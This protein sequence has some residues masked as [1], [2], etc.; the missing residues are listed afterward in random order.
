MGAHEDRLSL[1]EAA[2]PRSNH[3]P[4]RFRIG[5]GGRFIEKTSGGSWIRAGRW[6]AA[7]SCPGKSRQV[8][9]LVIEVEEGIFSTVGGRHQVP[10]LP[11][12][13]VLSRGE[14]FMRKEF[15]CLP[16]S[17]SDATVDGD[18]LPHDRVP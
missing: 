9:R 11:K 12:R 1:I 5:T 3:L 7:A 18:I 10:D 15:R 8:R 4:C 14:V 17:G 13:R 6:R 16:R 2:V